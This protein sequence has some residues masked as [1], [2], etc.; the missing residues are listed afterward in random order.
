MCLGGLS[1]PGEVAAEDDQVVL[2]PLEL[3]EDRREGGCVAVDVREDGDAP[4]APHARRSTRL[5]T[6]LVRPA[7]G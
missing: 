7:R 5:N 3:V 1:S 6:A 2:F 4:R